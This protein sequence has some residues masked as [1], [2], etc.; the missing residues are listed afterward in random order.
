MKTDA[1]KKKF[2]GILASVLL[3]AGALFVGLRKEKPQ[4]PLTKDM[5]LLDTFC[6]VTLYDG[7]EE[8]L[9]KASEMLTYYDRLFDAEDPASD[10]Y[11]INHRGT[12]ETSVAIS[13]DTARMLSGAKEVETFSEGALR[14]SIRPVTKLWDFKEKKE[15]PDADLLRTAC[16][17]S[18]ASSWHIEGSDETGYMFTADEGPSEIE[19]GAYA[20]GY[21]ADRIRDLLLSEGV[22]SAI[23]DLGGN[24]QTVGENRDKTPFRIGIRDPKGEKAAV[25]VVEAKDLS[26]VTAGNYERYFDLDGVR[27]HHILDPATGY[28]VQNE[29]DSVTVTGPSSF[30]CDAFATA[31]FVKGTEEGISMIKDYNEKNHTGYRAYF[32]SH[33]GTMR[34][35]F[36]E[37]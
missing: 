37:E 16:E 7:S 11:R 19:I 4:E 28:P 14:T 15:I 1:G 27:Y 32:L 13:S 5:F 10:I 20:K 21:I 23:I 17:E 2:I 30:L 24:V 25:E 31:C 26:V 34:H 12:E 3:C 6:T 29:L 36:P 18:L 22:A 33:D 8:I 35:S 9:Q